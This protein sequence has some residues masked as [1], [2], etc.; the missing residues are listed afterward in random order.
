MP[1]GTANTLPTLPPDE[2]PEGPNEAVE[3]QDWQGEIEFKDHL[4]RTCKAV[5]PPDNLVDK[6]L[7]IGRNRLIA[8]VVAGEFAGLF[9][10]AGDLLYNRIK[11]T[12]TRIAAL[13]FLQKHF[14]M[15]KFSK[16]DL[17]NNRSIAKWRRR[18]Q[19]QGVD[20]GP[21]LDAVLDKDASDGR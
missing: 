12:Q 16:V 18:Y 7:A 2:G 20:I 17:A 8:A 19:Q 14:G 21:I 1:D 3:T 13:N 5:I 15:P 9:H 10:V 4:G 6:Y 11:D